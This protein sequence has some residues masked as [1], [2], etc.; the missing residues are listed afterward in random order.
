MLSTR[1]Y[2]KKK[3]QL[4]LEQQSQSRSPT[5]FIKMMLITEAHLFISLRGEFKMLSKMLFV[6]V[7]KYSTVDL[8]LSKMKNKHSRI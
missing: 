1:I 6:V 2:G 8:F 4:L 3:R 7:Q 5:S